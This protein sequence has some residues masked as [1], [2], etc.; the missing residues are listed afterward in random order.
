VIWVQVCPEIA[1]LYKVYVGNPHPYK[2]VEGIK[3]VSAAGVGPH[4]NC[5]VD[6][7]RIHGWGVCGIEDYVLEASIHPH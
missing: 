7:G 1:M 4:W 2:V 6:V 5:F 3:I